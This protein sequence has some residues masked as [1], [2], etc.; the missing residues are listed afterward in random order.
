MKEKE[1]YWRLEYNEKVGQTN[2]EFVNKNNSNTFGWVTICDNLSENQSL[3]F[4]DLI[5]GKYPNINNLNGVITKNF[6]SAS[7]IK[8]DFVEFLSSTPKQIIA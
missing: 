6:P 2:F 5:Y 4:C 3:E 8:N 7:Q 1:Y